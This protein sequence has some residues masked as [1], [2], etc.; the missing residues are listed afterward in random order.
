VPRLVVPQSGAGQAMQA[1]LVDDR[2]DPGQLGDLMDQGIGVPFPDSAWPHPGTHRAH[3]R[4]TSGAPRGG[5]GRG[6]PCD[7]RIARRASLGRGRRRLRFRPFGS[8]EGGLKELMELSR[9]LA[10][11]SRTVAS[12]AA[13]RSS[14][15]FQ[16]SGRAAW[17]SAGTVPRSGSGIGSCWLICSNTN[18]CANCS[19]GERLLTPDSP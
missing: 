3:S 13:I 2:L 12:R 19:G 14:I 5:T 15:A 7:G 9:S 16:A 11:R 10:W 8:E 18:H 4:W 6:T 17:A 1:I